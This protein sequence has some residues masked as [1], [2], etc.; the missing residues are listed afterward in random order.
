MNSFGK[1]VYIDDSD[2]RRQRMLT[3]YVT[4]QIASLQADL[5]KNFC[6]SSYTHIEMVFS[7]AWGQKFH[8]CTYYTLTHIHM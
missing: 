4:M 8:S 7:L 6:L 2:F 5:Y 1:S 3:N